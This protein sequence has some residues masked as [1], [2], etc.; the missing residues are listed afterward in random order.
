MTREQVRANE[1][2]IRE[3]ERTRESVL[4]EATFFEDL[5]LILFKFQ[6]FKHNRL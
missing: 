3:T 6:F 1:T 4:C 5:V 2:S